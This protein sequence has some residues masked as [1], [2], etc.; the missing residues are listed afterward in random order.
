MLCELYSLKKRFIHMRCRIPLMLMIITLSKTR[1]FSSTCA[2]HGPTVRCTWYLPEPAMY[3]SHPSY[4]KHQT[5]LT[6]CFISALN[7][8]EH[9]TSRCHSFLFLLFASIATGTHSTS[10]T[11]SQ[12]PLTISGPSSPTHGFL[13]RRSRSLYISTNTVSL[14]QDP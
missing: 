10:A 3:F 7:Q 11:T 5:P 9:T 6:Y 13:F 4:N 8:P 12:H 1:R 14:L 2:I